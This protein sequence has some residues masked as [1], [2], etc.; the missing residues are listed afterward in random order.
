MSKFCSRCG[1]KKDFNEFYKRTD[2]PNNYKSHCIACHKIDN[3]NKKEYMKEYRKIYRRL[4]KE[5]IKQQMS[6]YSQNNKEVLRQKKKDYYNK[7]KEKFKEKMQQYDKKVKER[8]SDALQKQ[9]YGIS[10]EQKAQM[11]KEQGGTCRICKNPL[12]PGRK[13]PTDHDH[14]TGKVRGI[15]CNKC[16]IGLGMFKDNIEYLQSAIEYLNKNT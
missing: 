11:I 9:K 12:E 6:L 2:Q 16:N 14:K 15:L 13:S 8:R 3:I 7:N 4:N 5:K 1:I 10:L